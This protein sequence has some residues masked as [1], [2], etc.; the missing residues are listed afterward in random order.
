MR[1][2]RVIALAGVFQ[3][4][5]LVRSIALRGGADA[6]AMQP[7]LD[8]IFKIDADSPADVFGGLSNL[9]QGLETLIAQLD[10]DKRDLSI[11]RLAL[12]V[13]RVESR[14]TRRPTLLGALRTGIETIARQTA[15]AEATSALVALRLGQLYIDTISTIQPRITVEGDP[16]YLRQDSQAA[17]IRALLLAAIRAA[18]LWRQLGGSQWRLVFRR[19]QYSMMARGLLAQCK[20]SGA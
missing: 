8:S 19:G 3:A 12:S 5:A 18:V 13:M 9:R 11:T 10:D 16:Q 4:I 14:L 6:F 15:G 7:S 1:E 2:E 20:L 17:Q